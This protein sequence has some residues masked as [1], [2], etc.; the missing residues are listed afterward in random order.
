[1]EFN[2]RFY[3]KPF[4]GIER[5]QRAWYI[6]F[7]I[8]RNY[9]IELRSSMGDTDKARLI[10]VNVADESSGYRSE[11]CGPIGN[12]SGTAP[13]FKTL[14]STWNGLFGSLS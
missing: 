8:Q 14:N 4:A 10:Y 13:V 3:P 6:S 1:M 7:S 9:P 5:Y 11:R 12:W 2:I